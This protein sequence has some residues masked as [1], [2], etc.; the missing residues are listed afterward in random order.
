MMF[1]NPTNPKAST[2]LY[3]V[4]S[5]VVPPN[6]SPIDKIE[7]GRKFIFNF[8]YLT[9]DG[10]DEEEFKQYFETAFIG[11]FLTRYLAFETFELWQIKL[12]SK[13]LLVMPEYVNKLSTFFDDVDYG[14]I[15]ETSGENKGKAKNKS[16]SADLPAGLIDVSKIGDVSY[17]DNGNLSESENKNK[18]KSVTKTK[19]FDMLIKYNNY[20]NG[21]FTSLIREFNSLFS[22]VLP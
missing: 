7:A 2:T 15:T 3:N 18:N 11:E 21:L 12:R 19:N 10:V 20:F 6:L 16:I 17:A 22:V 14:S 13:M 9:P 4:I 8:D 1:R 5:S